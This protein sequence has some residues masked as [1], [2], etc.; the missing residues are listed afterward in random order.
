MQSHFPETTSK[1]NQRLRLSYSP[2]QISGFADD[3]EN[4]I[5]LFLNVYFCSRIIKINR[6]TGESSQIIASD[7]IS[8][9]ISNPE[10][11]HESGPTLQQATALLPLV[12]KC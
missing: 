6:A 3:F 9:A 10:Y 12:L 4:A 8:R 1:P 11:F 5:I 7:L 2:K